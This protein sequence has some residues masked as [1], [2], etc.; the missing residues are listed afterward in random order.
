MIKIN[1]EINIHFPMGLSPRKQQI[2]ALEF[3]KKSI[4]VGKKNIL[5]GLPTGSGKSYFVIMFAN[6]Y[7]NYIN[8]SAKFDII[9]NTKILQ[10]QYI[11]DYPFIENLKGT[12]N[13]YCGYHKTNCSEGKEMNRILK[14]ICKNCPYDI[15]KYR[16][17]DSDISITNF[18]LFISMSLYTENIIQKKSNVLIIDEAHDF[19]STFSSFIS[20]KLNKNTLK[21]CGFSQ[22]IQSN[23]NKIFKKI[24]TPNNFIDFIQNEFIDDIQGIY[25]NHIEKTKNASEKNIKTLYKTQISYCNNLIEQLE[26]LITT[27][28]KDKNNW[29]LDIS[30]NDKNIELNLQPIWGYPYMENILWKNYDHIIFMSG[31]LLDKGMFSY[32]NGLD[33]KLTTYK[34]MNSPF[35]I[36][37]RPIFY[38]KGIGKMTFKEKEITFN[39]QIKIIEKIL[40]KYKNKKGIIHTTNY[41]IANWI[42]DKIKDKRLMF[43]K[44]DDRDKIYDKFIKSKKPMVMVSPSMI[45]GISLNDELSRFA[46]IVKIGYPN[47]SSNKI[48][49]RQQS[50]RDWYNFSTISSLI[51]AYGRIIRSNDDYGDTFILD[52]SFSNV[53]KYNSK[54]LPRYFTNAIKVLKN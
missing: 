37:K 31:T 3:C 29:A 1:D 47:I 20:I 6:W 12:S 32:I 9:T 13:Y 25:D 14:R 42:K 21:K 11:N 39:K 5:M 36:K 28:N 35:D 4:N 15:A 53:L 30:Y 50:N 48:K 2:D 26:S 27:Y 43:H 54:Y 41:E 46:I 33:I 17:M 49:S 34:E 40:K 45:T 8:N 51:Q 23:Y 10:E 52:D 16:W 24:K 7:R 38:I 19:E 18:A 22:N 44:S